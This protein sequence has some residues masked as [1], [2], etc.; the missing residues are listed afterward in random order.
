MRC[1]LFGSVRNFRG[2]YGTDGMNVG[3][4]IAWW[5]AYD[6]VSTDAAI[7][8]LGVKADALPKKFTAVFE[9]CDLVV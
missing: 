4:Q 1:S 8:A 6:N 9:P 3:R 2:L 5:I 7:R